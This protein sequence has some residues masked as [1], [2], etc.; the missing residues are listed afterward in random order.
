M[1]KSLGE[2]DERPRTSSAS[3]S[4][5]RQ[6]GD[7]IWRQS[8]ESKAQGAYAYDIRGVGDIPEAEEVTDIV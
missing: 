6:T 5:D 7:E 2:N 1:N 4:T 3:E 8:I